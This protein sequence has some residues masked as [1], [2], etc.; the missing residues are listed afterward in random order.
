MILFNS[1]H[2]SKS[3]KQTDL[4]ESKLL[5]LHAQFIAAHQSFLRHI[6]TAPDSP[7]TPDSQSPA[8]TRLDLRAADGIL[9]TLV[10]GFFA[11]IVW[12]CLN[13][14][15][16]MDNL[17]AAKSVMEDRLNRELRNVSNELVRVKR[18]YEEQAGAHIQN[19]QA[20]RSTENALL[21]TQKMLTPQRARDLKEAQ[22][23]LMTTRAGLAQNE[24]N[25]PSVQ[26]TNYSEGILMPFSPAPAPSGGTR[27]EPQQNMAQKW[28]S[29][30]N[31]AANLLRALAE[32]RKALV[33]TR[34]GW[35]KVNSDGNALRNNLL[36]SGPEA[37]LPPQ[38]QKK[39]QEWSKLDTSIDQLPAEMSWPEEF[40]ESPDDVGKDSDEAL[41]SKLQA[42]NDFILQAQDNLRLLLGQLM[43]L[44]DAILEQQSYIRLFTTAKP[45]A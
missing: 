44:Q 17:Q 24:V 18:I 33:D 9:F 29:V 16:D 31:E 10:I 34:S 39:L 19:Q 25:P 43:K 32:N 30:K 4:S 36:K 11:M 12:I 40:D 23:V 7:E 3:E 5:T 14:G 21:E 26:G 15:R 28:I 35:I 13:P 2:E 38:L 1:M 42:G 41:K 20:L 22:Q 45:K 8:K 37:M 27:V 6:E